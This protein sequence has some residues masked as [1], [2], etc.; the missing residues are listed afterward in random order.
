MHSAYLRYDR[1]K[2]DVWVHRAGNVD[3]QQLAELAML[4]ELCHEHV[5]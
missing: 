5:L 2:D 4:G 3:T 1:D